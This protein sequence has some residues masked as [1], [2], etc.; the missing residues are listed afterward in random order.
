ME[1]RAPSTGEEQDMTLD[2]ALLLALETRTNPNLDRKH[3]Q[4]ALD[5]LE[6]IDAAYNRDK[7]SGLNFSQNQSCTSEIRLLKEA[8]R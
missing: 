7:K 8:L 4:E 5:V 1:I 2:E 3:L 6:T